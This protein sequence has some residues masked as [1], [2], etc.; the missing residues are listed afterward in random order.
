MTIYWKIEFIDSARFVAS[1]LSSLVDDLAEGIH[2]IKCKL[3]DYF[4][5]YESVKD[6]SVKWKCAS[7]DQDYSKKTDEN[8]K[9]DSKT[10][11][12]FLIMISINV[13]CC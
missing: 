8:L 3:S 6:N 9:N 4:L 12:T 11:L 1:S 7:C 13:F 5:E 2:T 10:Y